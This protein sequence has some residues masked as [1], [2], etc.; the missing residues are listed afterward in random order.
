ML[1]QLL[2][3][4]LG[5]VCRAQS[6]AP[7]LAGTVEDVRDLI[8]Y[9]LGGDRAD[10]KP[11]PALAR[12]WRSVVVGSVIDELLAGELVIRIADP[13]AEQPFVLEPH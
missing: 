1:G 3:A 13:L 4:A 12:G 10:D 9:R 6:V 11:P 8:A 5:S 7:S 2:A